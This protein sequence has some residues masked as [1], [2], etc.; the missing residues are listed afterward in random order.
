MIDP[1][2]PRRRKGPETARIEQAAIAAD[3]ERERIRAD[4][5][6][7][8]LEAD[9]AKAKIAADDEPASE[10]PSKIIRNLGIAVAVILLALGVP[11]GILYNVPFEGNP[12]N[13][14]VKVGGQ[15]TVTADPGR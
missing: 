2:K 4:V 6:K 11:L 7:A 3:V 14:T 13:G 1:E 15:P 5:E 8:R 12:L 10:P 9:V